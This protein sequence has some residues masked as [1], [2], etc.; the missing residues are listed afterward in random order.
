MSTVPGAEDNLSGSDSSNQSL[1]EAAGPSRVPDDEIQSQ[2][3]ELA[4]LRDDLVRLNDET[5][6]QRDNSS[7]ALTRSYI[8]VP[9]ERQVQFFCGEW[10]KDGRSVEEFIEEV[11]RVIRTREQTTEEKCDFILS[12]L[13]G[14]ALEEVRLCMGNRSVGSSDLFSFLRNAFGERRSVAQLLQSFYNRKQ[15]DGEDLRDYSHALSQILSSVVKQSTNAVPDEKTVLRDQFIEGLRH[16]PLRRELRKMVRERPDSSLLDVRNEALLW[17]MED[18]RSHSAKGVRNNMVQSGAFETQCSLTKTTP[19]NDPPSALDEVQRAVVHQAE[20]LAE[21]GKA[22]TA[23]S[24]AV[25]EL[26]KRANLT[27]PEPKQR[28]RPQPAFTHDGQP[29][30]FKCQGVGHIARRCPQSKVVHTDA[31]S[32]SPGGQGN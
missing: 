4:K 19:R 28:V 26:C 3:Q 10:E 27:S 29:I 25:G 13:R 17:E 14:P 16:V 15:A 23:L 32:A 30:C 12:L 21:L 11:E 18:N 5:R 9:R 2:L 24:T 22:L 6:A 20:Q 8:Y 1:L 31:A 7:R